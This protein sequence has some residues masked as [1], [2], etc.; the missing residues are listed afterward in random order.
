MV[1]LRPRLRAR[2]G[3]DSSHAARGCRWAGRRGRQAGR[4]IA[5]H[6]GLLMSGEKSMLTRELL[7]LDAEVELWRGWLAKRCVWW[8]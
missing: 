6:S 8:T 5:T 1:V 7:H 4:A 2:G 3:G